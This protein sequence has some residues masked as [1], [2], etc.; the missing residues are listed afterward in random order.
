[1][2]SEQL[3]ES[4]FTPQNMSMK[5]MVLAVYTDWI[6][7]LK[8]Y[9]QWTSDTPGVCPELQQQQQTEQSSKTKS[10]FPMSFS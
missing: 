4:S 2:W 1:M 9:H 7:Q 10:S 8:H 3:A 5:C 6:T